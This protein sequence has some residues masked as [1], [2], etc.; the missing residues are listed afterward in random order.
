[1]RLPVGWSFVIAA[2]VWTIGGLVIERDNLPRD[3]SPNVSAESGQVPRRNTLDIYKKER[4]N[5]TV[6]PGI[7]PN[8]PEVPVHWGPGGGNATG[9]A[10]PVS[11]AG[12]WIT[13]RHVVDQCDRVGIFSK[14]EAQK[15]FWVQKIYLHPSADIAVLQT[16]S[17][18]PA[19]AVQPT[20]NK[21]IVGQTGFHFGYPQGKPGDLQT[22]LIGRRKLRKIGK[23]SFIEPAIAWAVVRQY[24][25]L[26][27]FG[28]ISGGP[29][30]DHEGKVVGVTVA[31]NI[32]RGRVLASSPKT[33]NDILTFVGARLDGKPSTEVSRNTLNTNKFPLHG[34]HLRQDLIVAKV[35]CKG[36]G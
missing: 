14:P 25:R 8:D 23:N 30:L 26:G 3:R 32:R 17:N 27:A 6:L 5:E 35:F 20:S 31:G 22:Q 1:M 36:R 11:N 9:T 7:S 15:G 10:F 34:N 2:V 4:L 33:I 29:V 12:V 28:G 24:P 16:N 21:L 18:P 13:A 19:L